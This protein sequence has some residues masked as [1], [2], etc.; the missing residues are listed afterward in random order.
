MLA[1]DPQRVLV[2]VRESETQDLLNRVTVYRDG[3]EP[4]AIPIIEKELYDRGVTAAQIQE[5]RERLEKEIVVAADGLTARCSFC[6]APAIA[7]AW[8]WHRL[9]GMIPLFPRHF[10]Y[11]REHRQAVGS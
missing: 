8:S 3:M 10:Y 4:E 5:H 2:N 1:F 11:C 9:W 7:H 6:H